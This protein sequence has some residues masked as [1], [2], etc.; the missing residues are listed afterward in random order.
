MICLRKYGEV[1][2]VFILRSRGI[3]TVYLLMEA[4]S[5]V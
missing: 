2:H 1:H 4:A 5:V 3:F